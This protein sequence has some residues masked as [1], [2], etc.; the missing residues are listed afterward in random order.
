MKTT[1]QVFI[2][3]TVFIY[4]CFS[5]VNWEFN[6]YLWGIDRRG[7]F[8]FFMTLNLFLSPLAIK[9]KES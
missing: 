4:L 8:I 3:L 6:P 5:F 9:L 2:F 7:L 1:I